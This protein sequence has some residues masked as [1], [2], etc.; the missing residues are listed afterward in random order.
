M[1]AHAE[2]APAQQAGE[3][4]HVGDA[5]GDHQLP[6][7]GAEQGD[8]PDREEEAGERQHDVDDAHDRRVG[9]AAE[10]AGDGTEQPTGDQGQGH[11]DDPDEERHAGAVDDPGEH[12]TAE[13]VEAEPVLLGRPG[14]ALSSE[15]IEVGLT[16]RCLGRQ[17]GSEDSDGDHEADDRQADEGTRVAAQSQQH[18]ATAHR[19]RRG[20]LVGRDTDDG[21]QL[22]DTHAYRIL[23]SISE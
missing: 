17:Q 18:V 9:G 8:E 22:A 1:V 13:I 2:H 19:R 3:H 10:V 15:A 12:V 16:R 6:Q 4:R 20:G 7:A 5:D 14:A 11:R 23:G 21:R